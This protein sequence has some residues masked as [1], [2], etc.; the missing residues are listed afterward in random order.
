LWLLCVVRYCSLR[1]ADHS[2]RE[3]LASVMFLSVIMNPRQ[4]G[5]LGPV[6]LL[7]YGK[8]KWA[9]NIIHIIFIIA[10]CIL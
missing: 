5:G 7:C 2:S 10:P 6:G 9:N 3:V 4:W 8:K 1:W